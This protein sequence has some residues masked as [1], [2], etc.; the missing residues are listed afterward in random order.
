MRKQAA[1][2]LIASILVSTVVLVGWRLLKP[3]EVVAP[4]PEKDVPVQVYGLGG[5][6]VHTL[7]KIVPAGE[8]TAAPD[9]QRAGVVMDLLKNLASEQQTTILLVTHDDKIFDRLD[10]MFRLRDDRIQPQE[11]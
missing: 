8:P 9:S 6:E 1:L 7:S 2:F 10:R 11:A 3:I 5:L 4:A